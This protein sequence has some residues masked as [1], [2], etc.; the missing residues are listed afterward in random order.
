[1]PKPKKLC[2][3]NSLDMTYSRI[4]FILSDCIKFF[5][6]TEKILKMSYYRNFICLKNNTPIEF[7]LADKYFEKDPLEPKKKNEFIQLYNSDAEYI[8]GQIKEIYGDS[9]IKKNIGDLTKPIYFNYPITG[10][11]YFIYHCLY[12]FSKFSHDK[13][14]NEEEMESFLKVVRIR[15]D[16]TFERAQ[17]KFNRS[18]YFDKN[19]FYKLYFTDFQGFYFTPET[20]VIN[21][22]NIEKY[23]FSE[24]K[25][26]FKTNYED[27]IYKMIIFV[28]M[29]IIKKNTEP[30]DTIRTFYTNIDSIFKKIKKKP[31]VFYN[32][33][34]KDNECICTSD[35]CPCTFK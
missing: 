8:L 7:D 23:Y 16:D 32:N 22:A 20:P 4:D 15:K 3:L 19:E 14:L 31:Y 35:Q 17:E 27:H 30:G 26:F 11:E 25:E 10:G 13:K 29:Y 5:V 21:I 24:L 28:S 34:M 2:K 6:V 33:F 9:Y 1:M 12:S 18:E